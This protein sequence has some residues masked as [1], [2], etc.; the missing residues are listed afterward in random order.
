MKKII[1]LG[2]TGSVGQNV[3]QVVRSFPDKFQVLALAAH[4]NSALLEKQI[5]EFQPQQVALFDQQAAA[6]LK[7]K[8]DC[9][10]LSKE[11]GLLEL[12]QLQD[13]DMLVAATS[14]LAALPAILKAIE[15]GK[16]I[17]LANKE[18]LVSAGSLV[19]Q[20]A[21]EKKIKILPVDSE[22]SAIF[23]CLKKEKK[24]ALKK[25]VLTASGGPFFQKNEKQLKNISVQD[26]LSHPTWQ[27][28]RKI[29]VDSST[30]MNKGLEVIEAHF[31]FGLPAEK[32]EVAI[33]PQS[34][35]HSLVEFSDHSIL[36]Q[37]GYPD[38][39][40]PILYA[41]NYPERSA[42]AG[43]IKSFDFKQSVQMQFFPPDL[44][45]FK[46]L[47]LAYDALKIGKSAPCYLNSA[48]QVL[49]E[50]FLKAEI[51]WQ[52]IAEKL[53]KLIVSHIPENVLDLKSILQIDKKAREEAEKI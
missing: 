27:M 7:R 30:L 5:L 47:Q 4:K 18:T 38:M 51:S 32:I 16:D 15:S 19:M 9:S 6:C 25:I 52:Q 34:L 14:G 29:T 2:S 31:L 21:K 26:A 28:G 44:K 10:V 35:I 17:A 23:Q 8:V 53:E 45:K 13:A 49:V 37:F 1:L 36:A 24:S 41:L 33:H 3:L 46:C 48:N 20:K 42:S 22:H 11:Q 40:L 43:K 50:R 39:Q 12:A